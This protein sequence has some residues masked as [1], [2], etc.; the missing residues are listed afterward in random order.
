MTEQPVI[1][2]LEAA[3]PVDIVAVEKAGLSRVINDAI[4]ALRLAAGSRDFA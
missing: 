2:L 4:S 3:L 1:D